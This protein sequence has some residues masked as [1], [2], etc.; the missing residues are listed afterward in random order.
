MVPVI[1]F[2]VAYAVTDVPEPEELSANQISYI[3]ASDSQTEIARLVPPEGNRQ[4]V[5]INQVP[6]QV[7]DAVVAAEDREFWTNPGFSFTGFGRAIVGQLTGND[8]AGGGS[9]ITQQYVKNAV[10]GN[11]RS[12]TRK[13]KELVVSMKMANQWSKEE[14]LQAYLN[15]IY[16]GRNAYGIA[17]AAQAYFGKDVSQLTPEEGAVLAAAIQRPSQLDPWTNRPEAE[18]RWNY[19]LDGMVQTGSIPPEERTTAKYPEVIDPAQNNSFTQVTGTNG[20]IKNQVMGELQRLGISEQ[21]VNTKGLRVTTTIDPAAQE[22]ALNAVKNNMT[23]EPEN[24]RSAVVSVDPKTGAVRAYYGGEEATGWDFANA[25]AQTGSTFKIFGLTAALQQGIPLSAQYSSAPV[26]TGDA[27]VTNVEGENCGVC[28]IQQALKMS[29][30]TSFIR[31]QGDLEHGAQDTADMAHNL[32]VAKELPGI[33]PTL[34]EHGNR[35][36]DGVIL[37]MYPVRPLDMATGLSTLANEGVWHEPHFVQKVE[38][39]SGDVLYEHK[40][41]T[42]GERR[43]DANVANNAIAAMTPI[44]AYSRHHALAGGRQSAAKTGTTQLGDT[45]NSKDAWMIGATPQLATSVWVGNSDNSA[46]YQNGGPMYGSGLPSDIWKATMDGALANADFQSFP[47]ANGMGFVPG[48]SSNSSSGSQNQGNRT[49]GGTET[50]GTVKTPA[51]TSPGNGEQGGQPA[52]PQPAPQPAPQQGGHGGGAN[53]GPA[54]AP[55]PKPAPAPAPTPAP[56]PQPGGVE[57]APGIT[58]PEGVL[59][60]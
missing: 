4:S 47:Q 28:S 25:P 13:L 35:P 15:T 8:S 48:G 44:A 27:T 42:E 58:V 19:V 2:G 3:Y 23:G 9:T 46:L 50:G 12:L 18:Q 30:N 32:G 6:K 1:A 51:G 52:Q 41:D 16:F 7:Q 17:A 39:V 22:S 59:P 20:H 5:Q 55:A 53:P 45:G 26:Q 29:L 49:T 56:K 36:Y 33:G 60:R 14:V 11:E 43:V 40:D 54:P 37:G 31:L 21:D 24:M 38:T 10:V 57:I 34:S